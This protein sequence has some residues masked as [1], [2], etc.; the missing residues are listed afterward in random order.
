MIFTIFDSLLFLQWFKRSSHTYFKCLEFLKVPVIT[1]NM[2]KVL[3]LSSSNLILRLQFNK[4]ANSMKCENNDTHYETF[5]TH[6]LNLW[7]FH[8]CLMS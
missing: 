6:I 2:E 3:L 5:S 1:S 7:Y 4:Y 8:S